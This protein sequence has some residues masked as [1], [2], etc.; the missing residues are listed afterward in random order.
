MSKDEDGPLTPLHPNHRKE[1]RL[2]AVVTM[3][4]LLAGAFA[5]E[6]AA[7]LPP[8][9]VIVP[10]VLIATLV[11]LR[12]PLSRYRRKGFCMGTDT[13]RVVR[14]WLWRS[15]TIVPF[16]RVQ[17]ID[18]T[19]GAIERYYGLSTLVLHTA[20]T[21]NASVA[22]PGLAREDAVAMRETIRAHIRRELQ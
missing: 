9:L 7:I 20:G 22:L 18:V 5:A 15:D 4:P 19:Q 16:G 3:A 2:R 21:H 11:I 6:I 10:V 12:I 8:G 1:L 14:G 17:H 13:L